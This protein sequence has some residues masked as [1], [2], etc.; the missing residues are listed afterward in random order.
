M[1]DGQCITEGDEPDL[2]DESSWN[3]SGIASTTDLDCDTLMGDKV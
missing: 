2:R 3:A 1:E